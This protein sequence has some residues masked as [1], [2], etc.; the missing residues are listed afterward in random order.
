MRS[1]RFP[2][3]STGACGVASTP[4]GPEY[5]ASSEPSR[6]ANRTRRRAGRGREILASPMGLGWHLIGKTLFSNPFYISPSAIRKKNYNSFMERK[7][8]QFKNDEE[9]KELR[10]KTK[11]KDNEHAWLYDW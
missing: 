9:M 2:V 4:P 7:Q 1:D 11:G 10:E 6:P 5:Q 8:K 3:P